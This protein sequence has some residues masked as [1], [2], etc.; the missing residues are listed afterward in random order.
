V[1]MLPE[2]LSNKLCSL[3]ENEDRLT[4]SV[5]IEITPRGRELEYQIKK[6]VIKSKKRFTY[7]EVQKIIDNKEGLF[8]E[9]ISNLNSIAKILRNKRIKNGS[10]N[11]RTNEIEFVLDDK[12]KPI[13]INSKLLTESNNLVEEFMLLANRIVCNHIDKNRKKEPFGFVYR[14][15]DQPDKEKI[16]D[17][18]RFVKNLGHHFDPKSTDKSKQFQKLIEE[19]ANK[20]EESIINELAIRSMAKAEYSTIN[21]GHYG[22]GFDHYTHFTSPI[23]RFPDLLVHLLIFSFVENNKK[24]IFKDKQLTQYCKHSSAQER[25]AAEAE[26]LSVKLKQIEYLKGKEGQDFIGIIS[27]VTN[28]G[29]FVQ[30]KGILAEGLIKIRDMEDDF[31]IFD[32]K[33]YLLKGRSKGKIYRLG[34]ELT[35]KLIRLDH[36]KRIIDFILTD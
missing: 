36:E 26:R 32:E 25:N 10:I 18:A 17:F 30:I 8:Y 35:I 14:V 34:D 3:V 7:K 20:P 15:H 13:E 22:L 33:N 31:Y 1:P 12:G 9:E 11:F 19:V 16:N 5:F 29:I 27:G 23:R 4:Y 28:F 21:I 6:T 24:V 2:K